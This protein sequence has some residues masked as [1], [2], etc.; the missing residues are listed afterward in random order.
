MQRYTCASC[1]GVYSDAGPD[2]E[3]YFHVCPPG[4]A[5]PRDERLAPTRLRDER[6][7]V[8]SVAYHATLEGK[9]RVPYVEPPPAELPRRRKP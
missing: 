9:G 4:T 2:G 5:D 3:Q 6:T 7:G 8:E 1:R